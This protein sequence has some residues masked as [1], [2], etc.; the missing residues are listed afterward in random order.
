MALLSGNGQIEIANRWIRQLAGGNAHSDYSNYISIGICL[1]DDFNRDPP[2]QAQY[3]ALDELIR[4]LRQRVGKIDGKYS[5]PGSH[6]LPLEPLPAKLA[7][8]HVS[9]FGNRSAFGVFP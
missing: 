3:Q 6:R 7:P 2:T 8:S 9:G 4:Y 1:V 5:I